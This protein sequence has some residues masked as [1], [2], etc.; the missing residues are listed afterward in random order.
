MITSQG[1]QQL[2]FKSL[3]MDPAGDFLL[4]NAG[5]G[6]YIAQWK[7]ASPQPTESEIETAHATWQAEQDA[8]AY[9]RTR[10]AAYPSIGDQLDMLW[11]AIDADATLKSNYAD[12]HT[13]LKTVKDANP[14][15]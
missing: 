3:N 2:G 14:K 15:P 6:T 7:S 9:A 4:E 10:E 11:H 5:A 8:Q 13:A 12:F 1:L